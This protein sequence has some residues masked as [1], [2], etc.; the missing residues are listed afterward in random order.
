MTTD[1]HQA[2]PLAAELDGSA[3]NERGRPAVR[4]G[5]SDRRLACL[6][7]SAQNGENAAYAQ[8]LREVAPML[9]AVVRRRYGFLQPSDVED[10]VQEILLSLHLARRTY[11]PARPFLPWLM[12]I[13]RNRM[14]DAG[15]RHARQSRH[16]VAVEHVP[17]TFSDPDANSPMDTYGDHEALRQAV[18]D[19][20]SG[21]RQAVELLKL[22]EMPLKEAAMATGTSIGAL[23]VAVH[24]A[25]KTLRKALQ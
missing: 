15:R 7:Q 10:V 14:A 5:G 2:R 6:M 11:D 22:R 21:Q 8:L 25:I 16:E 23:K 20:P 1:R 24:R 4:P 13:A 18:N 17:E 3:V 19:L 9:R 12:A